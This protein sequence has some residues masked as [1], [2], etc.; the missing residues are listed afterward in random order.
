MDKIELSTE[1]MEA[2]IALEKAIVI[3]KDLSENYFGDAKSEGRE[4]KF[5]YDD[6]VTRNCIIGDYLRIIEEKLNSIIGMLE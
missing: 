6:A 5:Y 2:S 3:Q 4:L 1:L